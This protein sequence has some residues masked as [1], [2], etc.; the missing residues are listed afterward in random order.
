MSRIENIIRFI[1]DIDIKTALPQNVIYAGLL[2][3]IFKNNTL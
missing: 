3:F 1:S 2:L